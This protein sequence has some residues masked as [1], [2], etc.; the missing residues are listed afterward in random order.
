MNFVFLRAGDLYRGGA[1]AMQI[2]LS[3]AF[4]KNLLV[5]SI[6]R[7]FAARLGNKLHEIV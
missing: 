3:V 6:R 4:M 2:V 7:D 1:F 5:F